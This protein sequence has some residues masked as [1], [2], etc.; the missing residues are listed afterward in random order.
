MKRR[1]FKR[2]FI[3]PVL[4]ILL[5]AAAMIG[6]AVSRLPAPAGALQIRPARAGISLPDG[7]Y[8]YQGLSQHG[9]HIKSITPLDD[10]LV[11]QLD[12]AS[13]RKMAETVLQD[14]LPAGF[15]IRYYEP[16]HDKTWMAKRDLDRI[17]FG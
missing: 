3:W 10:A 2:S 11:V 7:F 12:T 4:L 1:L 9:I 13:Q 14:I 15:I 8:V 17:K 5:A 16:P 6:L